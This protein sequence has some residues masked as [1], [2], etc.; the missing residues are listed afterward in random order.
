MDAKTL[1]VEL[2]DYADLATRIGVSASAT[3]NWK[4]RNVIP[5]TAWPEILTAF[6]RKVTLAR[7]LETERAA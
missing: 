7:L 4:H 5:R 2:G 6:P 1:I 3:A